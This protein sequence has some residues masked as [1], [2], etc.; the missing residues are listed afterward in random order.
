MYN[1]SNLYLNKWFNHKIVK[2]NYYKTNPSPQKIRHLHTFP[3]IPNG[4][5]HLTYFGDSYW[6][7][8]KIKQF[9]HQEYNKDEYTNIN[10]II[11]RM[12]NST[13]IYDRPQDVLIKIPISKNNY[14]PP[15]YDKY[16][17]EFMDSI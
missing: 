5:W 14:L 13:D 15:D 2:Y 17:T 1:L 10:S 6:I 3:I 12:K 4:G 9:S 11:N 16:L 8:N 7:S